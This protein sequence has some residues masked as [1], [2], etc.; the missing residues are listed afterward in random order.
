MSLHPLGE[1]LLKCPQQLGK[2]RP[3]RQI[4]GLTWIK[5]QIIQLNIQFLLRF[6]IVN[7]PNDTRQAGITNCA[8][9][10]SAGPKNAE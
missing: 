3:S 8:P 2:L 7:Q 1:L 5:E 10:E 4:V 9:W 6:P